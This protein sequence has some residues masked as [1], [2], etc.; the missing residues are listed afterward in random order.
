ML[1]PKADVLHYYAERVNETHSQL[2]FE[3]VFDGVIA[4]HYPV[5]SLAPHDIVKQEERVVSI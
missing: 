5:G 3:A 2:I 4:Q 1:D